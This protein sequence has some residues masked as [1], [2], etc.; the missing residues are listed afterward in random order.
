MGQGMDRQAAF[1][2][3]KSLCYIRRQKP[4]T[5]TRREEID[6]ETCH[7]VFDDVGKGFYKLHG[8][9]WRIWEMLDGKTSLEAIVDQLCEDDE[10]SRI[11]IQTD[12]CKFIS[13]IGKKGL[14]KAAVKR[15][16]TQS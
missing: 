10:E 12:V 1:N 4:E 3:I 15:H 7:V 11:E 9:A 13:K 16:S 14:I 5:I 8:S 6:G 2:K